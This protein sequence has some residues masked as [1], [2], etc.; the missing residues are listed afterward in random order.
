MFEVDLGSNVVFDMMD[1]GLMSKLIVQPH[2]MT[3]KEYL[4]HSIDYAI[5]R[6][7]TEQ[8]MQAR[9]WGYPPKH[10]MEDNEIFP[11]PNGFKTIT[12][13][14]YRSLFPVSMPISIFNL[15]TITEENFKNL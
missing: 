6:G 5:N 12:E 9:T 15:Y 14:A 13:K 11:D 4:V 10:G 3:D 1:L 8:W 7:V 2:L